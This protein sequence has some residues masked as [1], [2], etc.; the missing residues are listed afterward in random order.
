[1]P[2]VKYQRPTAKGKYFFA[3]SDPVRVS[4]NAR[5]AKASD[6]KSLSLAERKMKG[7]WKIKQN[8]KAAC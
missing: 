7:K 5:K 6:K 1:M 8:R 3:A 4:K 2:C